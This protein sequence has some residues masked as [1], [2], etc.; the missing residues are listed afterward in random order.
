VSPEPEFR[1]YY[2]KPIIAEPVWSWEIP[3][4]FFT[5]G[6]GGASAVLAC[7]A[8]LSGREVLAR[9]AWLCSLAGL[10]ASPPLLISDL[11]KPARF[12]NM[13]RMVKVTSPMS[14]GTW[15]LSATSGAVAIGAAGSWFGWLE[16]AAA[17]ARPLAAVGGS[18][19]STYTAVLIADTAVP[20]WHDAGRELP[21]VFAG[22]AAASAGAAVALATPFAEGGPARSLAVVGAAASLTGLELMEKRLGMVGEVYSQGHAG[23]LGR[24]AKAGLG[25]GAAAVL[26]GSVRR[27]R[28]LSAGGAALVLGGA[29][30][31]RWS[32]FRAGFQ[33][34]R[35]PKYTVVPQRERANARAAAAPGAPGGAAQLASR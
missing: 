25:A 2:G 26:A 28:A 20:V 21:F 17:L 1:S 29:L 18:L 27:S 11:G 3:L 9:R 14:V 22:S 16:R 32:V 12:L 34:A 31:E 4:Y 24:A 33:S 8:E 6:L 23:M 7:G 35:D 10:G 19:V 15:L 30:L 5:G 13:L